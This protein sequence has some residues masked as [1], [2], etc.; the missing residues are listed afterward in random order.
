MILTAAQQ[1]IQ[2]QRAM[3][4]PILSAPLRV[5]SGQCAN[6]WGQNKAKLNTILHSEI[7]HIPFCH[8][9]YVMDIHGEQISDSVEHNGKTV[10]IAGKD[11]SE[12]PYLNTLPSV[13]FILSESYISDYSRKPCLTAVQIIRINSDT[14][15]FVAANF[16]LRKLPLT[17]ALYEE[18]T[19]W[20]QLKGDPSIRGTLFMQQRTESVLDQHIKD[21]M[22]VLNELMTER[23]VFHADIHYSSNR[24][25]IWTARDPK[26]YH[27]L[28]LDDLIDTDICL[29]YESAIYPEDAVIPQS[30]IEVILNMLMDLRFVDETIYLR[31][32]SINIFNGLIG[33]TFSCDG[34]HYMHYEEF[35]DKNI[36]FWLGEAQAGTSVIP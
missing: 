3:L 30:K 35:L 32:S 11:R 24:A 17:A 12:R 5:V 14:L 29:A 19:S 2:Q 13:D 28:T 15:G 18:S 36:L 25:M 27:I 22:I 26:K 16:E 23:G 21:V 8:S 20:R 7:K 4:E 31:N 10:E 6:S 33:L 34:S 1:C 9:L